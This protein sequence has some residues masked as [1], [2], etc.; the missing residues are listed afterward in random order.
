MKLLNLV[1]PFVAL[2][3][4][5]S[6]IPTASTKEDDLSPIISGFLTT[7]RQQTAA[8]SECK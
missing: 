6:A 2:F 8:I 1:L 7:V 5:V 3:T 4:A